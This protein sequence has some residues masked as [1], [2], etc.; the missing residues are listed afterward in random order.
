MTLVSVPIRVRTATLSSRQTRTFRTILTII[1]ILLSILL[2]AVGII[3]VQQAVPPYS[4]PVLSLFPYLGE[5]VGMSFVGAGLPLILSVVFVVLVLAFPE[6]GR[7]PQ[8]F[9]GRLYWLVPL[10]ICLANVV[11][12]GISHELY[13]GLALTSSWATGAYFAG[14]SL[15]VAYAWTRGSKL[16]VVPALMEAYVMGTMGTF[17]ADLVRTLTGLVRVPGE[18]AVWGGNGLLDL[19]FWFGI[20]VAW[21][22][23]LTTLVLKGASRIR[24]SK[25]ESLTIQ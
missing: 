3:W 1:A 12:F 6:R 14:A 22:E 24:P 13:G 8:A 20:Y 2:S 10:P 5:V 16:G 18:A 4:G 19:L 9:R 17:L 15:G 25:D 7:S 21:A 11:V 23:F